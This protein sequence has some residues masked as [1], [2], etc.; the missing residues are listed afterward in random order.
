VIH[1]KLGGKKLDKET[2]K[3]ILKD[4]KEPRKISKELK[5]FIL[6]CKDIANQIKRK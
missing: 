1:I 5:Q 2:A 4:L 6:K 3:E